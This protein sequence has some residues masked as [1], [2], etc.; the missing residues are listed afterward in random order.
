MRI[1]PHQHEA[2]AVNHFALT[3]RRYSTS[4]N[5]MTDFHISNVADS[6]WRTVNSLD[7]N[8]FDLL[9]IYRAADSMY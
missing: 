1:L 3:V 8:V 5:L 9:N 4:T 2:Q 7:H 6:N